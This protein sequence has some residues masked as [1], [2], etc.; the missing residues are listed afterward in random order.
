MV[1]KVKNPEYMPEDLRELYDLCME[2]QININGLMC[3]PP[4][5]QPSEDF[6]N[7]MRSLRDRLKYEFEFKYGNEQRL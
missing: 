3:I 6:F 7:E 2:K 4:F 1:K 5:D